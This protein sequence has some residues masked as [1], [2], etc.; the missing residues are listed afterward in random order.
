MQKPP[1]VS[2]S[3]HRTIYLLHLHTRRATTWVDDHIIG[4]RQFVGHALAVEHRFVGDIAEGMTRDG[5][6]VLPGF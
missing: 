2:I 1:D 5:L 6:E 4:D 3:N